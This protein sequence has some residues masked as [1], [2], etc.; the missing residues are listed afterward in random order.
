MSLL[1]TSRCVA[2]KSPINAA[3]IKRRK[4]QNNVKKI[5]IFCC[6]YR[7][8]NARGLRFRRCQVPVCMFMFP[9]LLCIIPTVILFHLLRLDQTAA[10]QEE[11][12][13]GYVRMEALSGANGGSWLEWP[14]YEHFM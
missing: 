7:K 6:Q 2:P 11:C 8:V 14:I 12:V 4:N 5:G 10:P 13:M 3:L 9:C 1:L